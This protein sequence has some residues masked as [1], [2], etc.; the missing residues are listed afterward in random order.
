LFIMPFMRITV[1]WVLLSLAGPAIPQEQLV[2][3]AAP[4]PA[5]E[6]TPA[7]ED[8]APAIPAAAPPARDIILVLDNSG[9]MKKNDP[10]LLMPV[11]VTAFINRLGAES[12]LGIIIFD[13]DVRM[14]VP[15]TPVSDATRAQFQQSLT[16]IDYK[17]L[18]TASPDA[19]ER[20]IYILK[21]SG[22]ADAQ[23]LI[24]FMT[25]GDVDTG[26][27]AV[28]LERTKWLREDLAPDAA[29]S[30]IRIFGIA[31][32]D[33]ADF[34]LIQSLAQ[35]T[36]GE[37]FRALSADALSGVFERINAIIDQPPA[38]EPEPRPAAVAPPPP[39]EPIVIEVPAAIPESVQREAQMRSMIV[40][41][42]AV[43]IIGLLVWI[44]VA[45]IRRSR[46]AAGPGEQ[47]VAEAYLKDLGG[48]TSEQMHRLGS[49]PTLL[50][51]VAG[52]DTELLDYVV[53]PHSTIGRRHALIEYKDFGYW[54]MD[55]GSINGTFVNDRPVTSEVRLKHGDH[56]RL[57]RTEF[58]FV[59]PE[60]G[61]AGMTVVSHTTYAGKGA[62]PAD[63]ESTVV[64]G[65]SARAEKEEFDLD[66][67][68][69]GPGS[70]ESEEDTVVRG[71]GQPRPAA[72]AGE[73]EDETLLPG[74]ESVE[75]AAP[76]FADSGDETLMP[77]SG[78]GP[79]GAFD[80]ED[81]T[82]L[83]GSGDAEAK[84]KAKSGGAAAGDEFF[85]ITGTAKPPD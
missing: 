64:K 52:K 71:K 16:L 21:S 18:L 48:A 29:E 62:A 28:D 50:G 72:P 85:D 23:K 34:Q 74:S 51:R 14:P 8:A 9:T 38:E 40:M 37:Y 24:V 42:S 59:M 77:G 60:I 76:A 41:V 54:I 65:A 79:G 57:H 3:D 10:Q 30:G 58:E 20:A 81:E 15:L 31:F 63:E 12:Q 11:A 2:P 70:A 55:Q 26:N 44:I 66:G 61:D 82:V 32:T 73:S 78:D 5:A 6:S 53:I 33:A 84:G 56:V 17:G 67:L 36:D 35:N 75:P 47:Y 4:A 27:E 13:K 68:H 46:D 83:P 80:T 69:A 1:A 39:P 49:K 22:R 43:V 25:D 7:V 19:V 45:L